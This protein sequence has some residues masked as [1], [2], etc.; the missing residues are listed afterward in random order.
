MKVLILSF[1]T[2]IR[3]STILTD[4]LYF[5]GEHKVYPDDIHHFISSNGLWILKIGVNMGCAEKC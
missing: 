1:S 3:T 4:K 5:S 2:K